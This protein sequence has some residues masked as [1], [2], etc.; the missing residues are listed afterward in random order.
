MG[1][2]FSKDQSQNS[3]QQHTSIV[4]QVEVDDGEENPQPQQIQII[5]PLQEDDEESDNPQ[6]QANRWTNGDEE[7]NRTQEI[8]EAY[9]NDLLGF[10]LCL[11]RHQEATR[12]TQHIVFRFEDIRDRRSSERTFYQI[13][14]TDF[15]QRYLQ[16]RLSPLNFPLLLPT[17]EEEPDDDN[18][19]NPMGHH[20]QQLALPT[21]RHIEALENNRERPQHISLLVQPHQQVQQQEFHSLPIQQRPPKNQRSVFQGLINR[22]FS[23]SK[24]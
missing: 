2:V 12:N 4:D 10:L 7:E 11:R 16:Q 17:E 19:L 24:L 18:S 1:Q 6:S 14:L 9:P 15:S 22:L 8:Q 5:Q 13:D 3:S 21:V 20:M 23:N